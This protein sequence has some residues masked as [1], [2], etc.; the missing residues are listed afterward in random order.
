MRAQ[1]SIY[2]YRGSLNIAPGH[3]KS[4]PARLTLP[5]PQAVLLQFKL[6]LP[7]FVFLLVDLLLSI[8]LL[9]PIIM[10]TFTLPCRLLYSLEL[11]GF[12]LPL[13]LFPH[14]PVAVVRASLAGQRAY[15]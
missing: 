11:G 3:M 8:E 14:T 10:F 12:A 13:P 4:F 9:H 7:P 1:F 15:D 5:G 6:S 2:S